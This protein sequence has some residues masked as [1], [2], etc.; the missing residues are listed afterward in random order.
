MPVRTG[1]G[2]RT[3]T[4]LVPFFEESAELMALTVTELGLGRVAGAVYLPEVSIVPREAEPPE[5][6]LTYQVIAVFFVPET[7]A[8]KVAEAPARTLV[9]NGETVTEIVA[10]GGGCWEPEEDVLAPQPTTRKAVKR[11][12]RN[13]GK[14][15]VVTRILD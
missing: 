12:A 7:V 11:S 15:R 6:S 4:A 5:V 1:V 13:P 8:E 3:V 9:V 10:G 14:V 2:L